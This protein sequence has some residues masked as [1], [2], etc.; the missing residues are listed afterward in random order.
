MS[1]WNTEEAARAVTHVFGAGVL[2]VLGAVAR[3]AAEPGDKPM[4]RPAVLLRICG[5]ASL[6]IGL[7]LVVSAM[8]YQGIWAMA[9][10]WIGGA[11]GYA[12]IHDM[13]LRVLNKR[14]GG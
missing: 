6:G 1:E 8:G 9:A 3:L 10:S 14:L 12:A 11:L 4:L 5:D 13:L 7:F 2:G